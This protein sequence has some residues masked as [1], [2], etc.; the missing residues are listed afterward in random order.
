MFELIPFASRNP[1][2]MAPF[3][4]EVRKN[5]MSEFN[6]ISTDVKDEGDSFV[7]KADMPGFKKEDIKI[8]I[9][10]DS[11]VIS[12]ERNFESE[13]E[14]DGYVHR[15]RR[16][17]SFRRT[18]DVSGIETANIKADYVDGVLTLGLPK[19]PELKPESRTIEIE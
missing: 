15:E 18:F 11:L 12:A 16:Y 17:G 10:D 13:E 2:F 5:G 19:L 4:P 9:E 3:F 8:S 1:F 7:I 14:R 6:R